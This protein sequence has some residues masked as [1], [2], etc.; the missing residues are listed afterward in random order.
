MLRLTIALLCSAALLGAQDDLDRQLRSIIDAFAIASENAADPVDSEQAMYA[1]AIL[2][3]LFAPI[4]ALLVSGASTPVELCTGQSP[5]G[6][7]TL[8]RPVQP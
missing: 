7:V 3:L 5:L 6:M 2:L 1:G 8:V 4:V